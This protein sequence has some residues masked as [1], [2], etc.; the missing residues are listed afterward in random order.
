MVTRAGQQSEELFDEIEKLPESDL[1]F[2]SLLPVDRRRTLAYSLFIKERERR[3]AMTSTAAYIIKCDN[4]KV[5][6]G[7]TDSMRESAAGGHC[8]ECKAKPQTWGR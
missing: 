8:D 2:N 5:Q 6:I 7:E 3:T 1:T 4:C